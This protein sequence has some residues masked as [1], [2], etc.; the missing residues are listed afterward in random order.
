MRFEA[1]LGAPRT[2]RVPHPRLLI[3]SAQAH[4]AGALRPL[5]LQVRKARLGEVKQHAPG[6][7]AWG[8]ARMKA[9]ADWPASELPPSNP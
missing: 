5:L 3:Q 7:T 6:H 9:R 2:V 8:G 1:H 4:E